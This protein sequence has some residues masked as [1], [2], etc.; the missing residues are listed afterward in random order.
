MQTQLQKKLLIG[1]WYAV[2]VFGLNSV[3]TFIEP[4]KL[5][6]VF[7]LFTLADLLLPRV[8]FILNALIA[9]VIVHRSYY[10]GGIINPGWLGW[11]SQDL[12]K[13]LLAI[14]KNGFTVVAPV[15]AMVLTLASL[16]FLQSFFTRLF[17]KGTGITLFLCSGAAM[18]ASL[19]LWQSAGSVWYTV[20]FVILGLVIK[21]TVSLKVSGPIPIGRWLGNLLVWVLVLV[22]V[23]GALPA[24]PLDLSSWL[25]GGSWRYDPLATT[26]GKVGY[27]S[28][29]GALGRPVDDD[30]TP[31][32]RVTAPVPMYLRGETRSVYNGR[33]W[34]SEVYQDV[35]YPE[36][37][38]DH[39]EGRELEIS[40]QVL[41]SN[42]LLFTP[43]YPLQIDFSS[44]YSVTA[45]PNEFSAMAYEFYR[46]G[47]RLQPGDTYT[48]TVLL[49]LDD[50]YYLRTLSSN[51]VDPRYRSLDNVPERVQELARSTVKGKENGY[52]KAVALASYLRYS[53]RYYSLETEPPPSGVDFVEDFLF[54]RRSGYCVHFSTAF[55]VM[56]RAVGLPARWVKGYG[57]GTAEDDGTYLIR[58]N[59][60]H[61]WAEVWFDGYGWVPFEPTPGGAHLRPDV[62]GT[63]PG[64]VGPVNPDRPDPSRPPVEPDPD[65]G[66]NPDP[67]KPAPKKVKDWRLYA[68]IGGGLV[69]IS[70]VF[71]LFRGFGRGSVAMI[72]TRLQSRLKL[73]GWQR[74]QWETPREHMER[75]D[76]LPDRPRLTGFVSGFEDSVYGGKDEPKEREKNLGKH[77][78]LLGLLYHRL[79]RVKG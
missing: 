12:G 3:M 64:A 47:A 57:Y 13:D 67:V 55:V 7:A 16:I 30:E 17:L 2:L 14:G 18:L 24:A 69:L 41:N 20:F 21:A 59:H 75:V 34:S 10:L 27:S 78:S 19:H 35:S 76:G 49:P 79:N 37:R 6:L 15:T 40:I 28:F 50:P 31:A 43:R 29:D 68:G 1:L 5:L 38:P 52:D 23:A 71:F 74:Q 61:S 8:G 46:F 65:P 53:G 26:K 51:E 70:F 62:A 73:F 56:A 9:L 11:L 63:D 25:E 42:K 77:Y 48:M 36:L 66:V 39:L 44:G 60:A 22:S 58:N 33:G 54:N 45:S 32:L 72:Y 4:S